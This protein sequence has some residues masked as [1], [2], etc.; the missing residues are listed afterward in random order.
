[1][2]F[3]PICSKEMPY[4]LTVSFLLTPDKPGIPQPIK[5]QEQ[6]KHIFP[7]N[8]QINEESGRLISIWAVGKKTDSKIGDDNPTETEVLEDAK[9]AGMIPDRPIESAPEEKLI[10]DWAKAVADFS[11]TILAFGK[12]KELMEYYQKNRA[13]WKKQY[14]SKTIIEITKMVNDKLEKLKD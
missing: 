11:R 13:D 12:K 2:G 3:Q 5:L 10:P 7:L 8:R 4:E 14:P 1:M 9:K 6:H